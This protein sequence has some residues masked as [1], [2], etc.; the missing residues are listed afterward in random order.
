[1]NDTTKEYDELLKRLHKAESIIN[2]ITKGEVDAILGQKVISLIRSQESI[3][4]TEND[5]I[6]SNFNFHTLFNEMDDFLMI[7]DKNGMILHSN[8]VVF[9]RLGYSYNE[10]IGKNFFDLNIKKSIAS[11]D[12]NINEIFNNKKS[13]FQSSIQTKQD[14]IIHIETKVTK[15]IWNNEDVFFAISRDITARKKIEDDLIESKDELNIAKEQAE[16]A[17]YA[18]SEFLANISHELRTPLNGILGYTQILLRDITLSQKQKHAIEVI[19]NSSEHLLMIINDILDISKIEVNKMELEKMD[20]HF[21]NFLKTIINI[22][23]LKSEEKGIEFKSIISSNI[24]IAF[25]GDEKRLRQILFNL[26]GNA[27]KFTVKGK[28]FFIVKYIDKKLYFEIKDD[29]IGIPKDKL[30]EIFL[31]FHQLKDSQKRNDGTGLGLAISKKLVKM[32]NSTLNVESKPGVGTKFWFEVFLPVAISF[33]NNKKYLEPVSY[34]GKKIK[35]LIV[36]DNDLNLFILETMLSRKGFVVYKTDNGHKALK[37]FN[38]I[39]PEI[40]FLDLKM[41]QINGFETASKIREL[42]LDYHVIIVAV[43]GQVQQST[44]NECINCG[45]DDFIAKPFFEKDIFEIIGKY[46]KIDWVYEKDNLPD[47]KKQNIVLLPSIEE[48]KKIY[49]LAQEGDIVAIKNL[50]ELNKKNNTKYKDFYN[51]IYNMANNYQITMIE[52]Y[53]ENIIDLTENS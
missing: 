5:L 25:N 17:N 29:G 53:L 49:S 35:I 34:K 47:T 37:I 30:E 41:P 16:S 1:M 32:M 4:K 31:P 28:I 23:K 40:V 2:A 27:V 8:P 38:S 36:D 15:G 22:F 42:E 50:I 26:L 3:K 19:H 51:K 45:F 12:C 13:I 18:K 52:N 46:L 48:I 7:I 21:P 39:K 43:S 33:N 24:P 14:K 9:E 20:F 10:L 11:N 44:K 6:E